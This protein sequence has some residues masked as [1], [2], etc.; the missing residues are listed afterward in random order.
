MLA[1]LAVFVLAAIGAVVGRE[2]YAHTYQP[3]RP[4]PFY[5]TGGR[6]ETGSLDADEIAVVGPPGTHAR[7]RGLARQRRFA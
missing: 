3:L 5:S 6:H 4:G 1:V 2:V 7:I